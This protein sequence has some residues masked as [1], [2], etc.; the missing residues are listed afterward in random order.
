MSQLEERGAAEPSLGRHIPHNFFWPY[1]QAARI[2]EYLLSLIEDPNPFKPQGC[3]LVGPSDGGKSS[4]LRRV[5]KKYAEA[6]RPS[7]PREVPVIYLQAPVGC[8]QRELFFTIADRLNI[9]F[10]YRSGNDKL[11]LK[12]KA[13]LKEA[14]TKALFV[15]ELNNLIAGPYTRQRAIID[16]LKDISNEIGIPILCAGTE[17]ALSAIN[18]SEQYRSRF[19]PLAME[20]LTLDT[21]FKGI[22][23]SFERVME[24]PL[25]TFSDDRPAELIFRHSNQLIGRVVWLL[26]RSVDVAEKAQAKAIDIKHMEEAGYLDLIWLKKKLGEQ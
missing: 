21:T 22:L 1:P 20:K 25:G 7:G 10:D 13:G 16:H 5:A 2:S 12:V 19:R 15:D 17:D 18:R 9:P 4:I 6:H 8:N 23:R 3:L 11:R 14:G 26:N 24:V